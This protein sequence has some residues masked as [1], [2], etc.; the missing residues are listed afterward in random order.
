MTLNVNPRQS[1]KFKLCIWIFGLSVLTFTAVFFACIHF[2]KIEVRNDLDMVVNSKL[3]YALRAL[4]E[5]LSTTEVSSD[6]LLS[7]SQSPLISHKRD[8]I[9]SLCQHFLEANPR[10]QGV[11]IGYEPGVVEGHESGFSPYIMRKQDGSYI[12][13]D[14]AETKDYR[15]S[16][17]YKVAHD[18]GKPYWSKPF[19]ESNGTVITSYNVPLRNVQGEVFAVVAVDLNLNVMADS[20]QNLRPYPTANLSVIDQ[21]GVFVAHENRDYILN[22]SLQ[23]IVAKADFAPNQNV[24]DEIAAHKRGFNTYETPDDKIYV[25]YAPVPRNG[26]TITLEVPRKEIAQGYDAMFKAILFD[27]IIGIVL[28]LIVC[29]VIINRM[30]RPLENFADA[31]RDISHGNFDMDL[32]VIKDHNELWDLRQAMASMKGSLHTYIHQLEDTTKSKALIEGELNTAR[33]IQMAM[34]PK[35]FPPYPERPELDI[36]GSL[37]PAKAVGGDL[38]DFVLDGDDFYFCIGDVSGKGVPAS[39]FMAIT[40]SLFRN[41][42]THAKSPAALA[43]LLNNALSQ[44]NDESMFVTMFIG[45]CNLKTGLFTCC[46]CGHNAPA[47]NAEYISFDPVTVGPTNEVHLINQVPINLPIGV[48]EGYEF[49]EASIQLTPGIKIM[50]Y[51]DGITEAENNQGKLYGDDRLL[52]FLSSLPK[53]TSCEQAVKQLIDDVHLHADGAEQ[54]DDITVLCMGYKISE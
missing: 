51:T 34:V 4:D 5:G 53:N 13:R 54:S 26:W 32:P 14:L 50:L 36:Y 15:Q 2:L 39:L 42:V 12:L 35:I 18:T 22:E 7:I 17:W 6:N 46:N 37:T 45:C 25:Y 10:I 28:M 30:T 19:R 31:A 16:D 38:Y 33:R 11:C 1:F 48:I 20:L 52:Q 41:N 40:R 24:L 3:D 43:T 23:S 44:G 49:K 21:D 29:V 47:T 9:Y 27:M 8:S